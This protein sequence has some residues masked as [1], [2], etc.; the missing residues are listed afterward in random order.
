MT[1]YVAQY[2]D[3]ENGNI[4]V[5]TFKA[6]VPILYKNYIINLKKLKETD[7]LIIRHHICELDKIIDTYEIVDSQVWN[8][9]NDQIFFSYNEIIE[10]LDQETKIAIL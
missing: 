10:K 5:M 4:L 7:N 1:L 3:Q 9:S 2:N 6:P 8:L